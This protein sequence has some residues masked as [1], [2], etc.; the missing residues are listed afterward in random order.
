MLPLSPFTQCLGILL[1]FTLP[2]FKWLRIRYTKQAGK[3]TVQA[4][5]D[6]TTPQKRPESQPLSSQRDEVDPSRDNI[7]PTAAMQPYQPYDAFLVLDVEA[8]CQPGTDFDYANE[9][10]EWP[11]CLLRWKHKDKNGN[12]SRLEIVDEFRSFV[13]P[14]WRPQLSSFCTA[15]TGITQDNVDSAPLFH[16]LLHTS[17]H[18]F[19]ARNGLIDAVT[20]A[21]LVPFCWC[22]DGPWDVRD[23]V[24]KQCFISKI[25][26]PPWLSGDVMDV[27]R[28]VTRWLEKND[29]QR[30][31]T[32]S[33]AF[34]S[35]RR[36][37]LPITRQLHLLGLGAFEGRQ[38]CG[39]DDTRN[40]A[41]IVIELARQGMPLRAN[42]PVNPRRRWQWMGK[43]GKVLEEFVRPATPTL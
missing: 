43:N 6:I 33:V 15:L 4:T 11:V 5:K 12:A 19:L 36:K 13:K 30:R 29:P 28:V 32:G 21:R 37:S 2:I 38:H 42:T 41:R 17:F 22:T 40:V 25:R 39:I 24:V 18:D 10:I 31:A 7:D 23:F 3:N 14:V 8:T 20:G 16:T 35:P 34:T 9:I 27:R 26:L 1:L